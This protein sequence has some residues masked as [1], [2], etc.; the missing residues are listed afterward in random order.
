MYELVRVG[1][2][3]LVGGWSLSSF[4]P[5]ALTAWQRSFESM[6]IRPLFRSTKRHLASPL[7]ILSSGRASHSVSNSVQVCTVIEF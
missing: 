1:H 7:V 6:Q 3:E 5:L 4:R 2:N